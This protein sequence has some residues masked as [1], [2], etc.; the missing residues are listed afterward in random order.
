MRLHISKSLMHAGGP[1]LGT[2]WV[3]KVF[4]FSA[5]GGHRWPQVFRGNSEEASFSCP[6]ASL[7]ND[8]T[9]PKICPECLPQTWKG[10][11]SYW[12]PFTSAPDEHW[13]HIRVF[14][15]PSSNGDGQ[16]AY[17][18]YEDLRATI[19][20]KRWPGVTAANMNRTCRMAESPRKCSK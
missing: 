5:C 14:W 20:D 17:P 15:C 19:K 8:A 2:Q 18:R 11:S 13:W 10:N 6:N 9:P 16:S 4:L 7:K 1:L 3:A 12:Y